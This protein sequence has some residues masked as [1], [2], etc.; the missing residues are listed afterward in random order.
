MSSLISC[1]CRGI[2]AEVGQAIGI[3]P[4]TKNFS[5]HFRLGELVTV[6]CEYY[7]TE[8]G[9]RAAKTIM[10]RFTIAQKIPVPRG[11]DDEDDDPDDYEPET[12]RRP[13]Q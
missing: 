5:I 7:P 2:G 3:P 12:M 10:E 1:R 6:D 8:N 13:T 11:P 9:V 4:H